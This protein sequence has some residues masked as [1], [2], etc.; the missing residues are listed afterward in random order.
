MPTLYSAKKISKIF[1]STSV[2]IFFVK[3]FGKNRGEVAEKFFQKVCH[4]FGSGAYNAVKT[5]FQKN[6]QKQKGSFKDEKNFCRR[7]FA[8]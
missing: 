6:F 2:G 4:K 8:R 5:K 3:I 7:N 1:I